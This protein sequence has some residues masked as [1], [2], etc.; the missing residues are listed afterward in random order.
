MSPGL[1]FACSWDM[2]PAGAGVA[3]ARYRSF[4]SCTAVTESA[5]LNPSTSSGYERRSTIPVSGILAMAA[6][7]ESMP[8][9]G[10]NRSYD[11]DDLESQKPMS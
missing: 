6:L 1:N 10:A 7:A 5:S 4:G 11:L 2:R 8:A 9:F 3:S